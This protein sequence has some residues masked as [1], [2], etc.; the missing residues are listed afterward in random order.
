MITREQ[1]WQAVRFVRALTGDGGAAMSW[2]VFDDTKRNPRAAQV[3]HGSIH[4]H[5]AAL[6]KNNADKCGVFVTIGETDGNGRKSSNIVRVRA[7]FVDCDTVRPTTWHLPP[8][9]IVES[10]AGPHAYWLVDD[11]PLDAFA[12]AQKRLA[13]A[14]NS[15]PVVHDLSRV[16]RVPGFL[17]C[18]AEP[19]L[20][21][22][23]AV[24]SHHY[25]TAQVLDGVPH[26]PVEARRTFTPAQGQ[27]REGYGPLWRRVNALQA[28][29]DAGLYGRPLGD[30]K[31]AVLCPWVDEHSQRDYSGRLGDT[32]LWE[33]GTSGVGVFRCSHAHCSGRYL[34]HA[35][36]A[37]GAIAIDT[38]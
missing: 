2:Q 24:P 19:R 33:K 13:L 15:D 20:V 10:A 22:L 21:E 14:Y 5:G 1:R 37:I 11:C 36:T 32:V 26:L 18:K 38:R 16:M 29:V 35:L 17:H 28:F 31:H 25:T 12:E 30:G 8:S 34:S 7:L 27:A 3:Y 6:I 4:E 23:A 9:I